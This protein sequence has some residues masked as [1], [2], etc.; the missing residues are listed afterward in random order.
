MNKPVIFVANKTDDPKFEIQKAEMFRL[1]YGEPIL[2]S[3]EQKLGREELLEAISQ[4]LP[5]DSGTQVLGDVAMKLAIVGRRN[6]GKST[7]INSLA[8]DE[9]CI[10]SEVAGTTRDSIDVRFDRDGLSFMAIDTAGVR[11]KKRPRQRH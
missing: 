5:T 4:H 1:G 9:R 8:Q 10:V 3:A 7:F 6:V 2:V 11:K